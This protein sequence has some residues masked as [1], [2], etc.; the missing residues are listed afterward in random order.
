MRAWSVQLRGLGLRAAPP[1]PSPLPLSPW[2]S[3]QR[4]ATTASPTASET[5]PGAPVPGAAPVSTTAVGV[6]SPSAVVLDPSSVFWPQPAST[7]IQTALAT[8]AVA[9]Q[10]SLRIDRSPEELGL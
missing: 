3:T 9:I 10:R 5:S 4:A 8:R 1:G 2:Q 7:P 6:E